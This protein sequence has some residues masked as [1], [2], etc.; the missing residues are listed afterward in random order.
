MRRS[1]PSSAWLSADM[2]HALAALCPPLKTIDVVRAANTLTTRATPTHVMETLLH[3]GAD[4]MD[5]RQVV[6]AL[7]ALRDLH[8]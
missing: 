6:A 4:L 7:E 8:G 3:Q 5:V 2:A 1:T